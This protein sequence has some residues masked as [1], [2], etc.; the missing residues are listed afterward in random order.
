MVPTIGEPELGLVVAAVFHEQQPV[1][2]GDQTVGQ[3]VRAEQRFVNR[4][5]IVETEFV[6]G[7][8]DLSDATL[9]VDP[10]P[11]RVVGDGRRGFLA[12]RRANDGR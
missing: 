4:L 7:V 12:V 6:A 5:L 9:E 2:G 8:A 3:S 1:T 10:G 11:G